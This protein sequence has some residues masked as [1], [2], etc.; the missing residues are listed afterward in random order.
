MNTAS[1]NASAVH[2]RLLDRK[3]P[4]FEASA[5]YAEYAAQDNSAGVVDG[6]AREGRFEH[7][8]ISRPDLASM[9]YEERIDSV[10]TCIGSQNSLREVLYKILVCCQE[11]QRFAQVEDFV[12]GLDE[13][14]YGHLLQTPYT[15]INML[16][17]AGGI[18]STAL[19]DAGA[20]IP[21]SHIAGASQLEI[22]QIASDFLL[23]TSEAGVAVVELLDPARRLRALLAYKPHRRDTFLAVIGFCRIPRT[24]SEIK[25]FY[26]VHD[27]LAKD[28]VQAHHTLAPDYYVDKLASAGGLVWQG[29][30]VATAAGLS[31]LEEQPVHALVK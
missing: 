15:L 21:E 25:E 8:E 4:K 5:D 31:L 17:A 6:E 9:T 10:L 24:F 7:V 16:V 26:K 12:R 28:T 2:S 1:T 13:F 22:E 20:P 29:A 19:D 11:R 30:W 14:A 23:E 27:E 18:V 3:L